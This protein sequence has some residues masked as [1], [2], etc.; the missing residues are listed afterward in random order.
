MFTNSENCDPNRAEGSIL[1]SKP[2]FE[3][4][5]LGLTA[6]ISA[7]SLTISTNRESNYSQM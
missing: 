6:H 5:D 7:D 2:H 4:L 1:R 3:W